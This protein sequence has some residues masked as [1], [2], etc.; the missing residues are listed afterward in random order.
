MTRRALAALTVTFLLAHAPSLPRTLEDIDSVNFAL[1]VRDFD[2][3]RH[4]PHPPGYPVYIAAAKTAVAVGRV[5]SGRKGE[6]ESSALEA[7]ALALLSLAGAALA[8]V[9]LY[10][11]F[12]CFAPAGADRLGRPWRVFD[13]RALAATALAVAC[14]LFWYMSVRPMSDVPGLAAALA[15]LVC[16]ALAWWRQQPISADDRRL[17]TAHVGASGRMIVLG[18]L[19]AAFSIGFRSQNAMLTVPFLLLVLIDRSAAEWRV[20]SSARRSHLPSVRSCGP[21]RSLPRAAGSRRSCGARFAGRRGLRRRRH[22]VL[23]PSPRLA[24]TALLRTMVLPWDSLV[25]GSIVLV[26]AASGAGPGCARSSLA[27][28]RHRHQRAVLDLPLVVSGHGFRALRVAN[29]SGDRVS[30]RVRAGEDR[31]SRRAS[32]ERSARALGRRGR[33]AVPVRLQR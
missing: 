30:R 22:V 29:C 14:P 15:A 25:L 13:P 11:V 24:A 10:R 20:R 21:Y 27:R 16:L 4:R 19:L 2:I 28:G 1:G 31:R 12:C 32:R 6:G 18:A 8:I 3:A 5:L 33:I 7:R 9:C 26:L 17:E 23:N